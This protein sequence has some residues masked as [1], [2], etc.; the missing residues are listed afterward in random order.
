MRAYE[1]CPIW[2]VK[3][4]LRFCLQKKTRLTTIRRLLL[5]LIMKLLGLFLTFT[6][7][8]CNRPPPVVL[9]RALSA[10]QMLEL[11]LWHEEAAGTLDS[12]MLIT[13]QRPGASYASSSLQAQIKRGR[14]IEAY[15]SSDGRIVFSAREF[16]GW[17][18][19]KNGRP[20]IVLC[21][22]AA[23]VCRRVLPIAPGT[24][25]IQLGTYHSGEREPFEDNPAS[26][27]N[28]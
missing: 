25:P 28:D 26:K 24:N 6:L 18:Y 12:N 8:G 22:L 11:V 13:V 4:T 19:S 17:T 14:D 23:Q 5:C 3:W 1:Q 15:W 7:I 2:G 21:G 20:S 16:D 10:D 27:F 9:Q